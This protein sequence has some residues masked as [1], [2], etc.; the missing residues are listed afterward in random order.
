MKNIFIYS[1][2]ISTI[3]AYNAGYSGLYFSEGLSVSGN[4]SNQE[5]DG[6]RSNAIS[7]GLSY[8]KIQEPSEERPTLSGIYEIS[9]FYNHIESD[10][11][12]NMEML[13]GGLNYY[14]PN[15]LKFGFHYETL[16]DFSGEELDNFNAMGFDVEMTASSKIISIGYYDDKASPFLVFIELMNLDSNLSMDIT[17]NGQQVLGVED[18]ANTSLLRFGAGHKIDNLAIQAM[19]TMNEDKF[20]EARYTLGVIYGL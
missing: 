5:E 10:D 15:N 9:G 6:E 14:M 18:N 4:Y 13:S 16:Y 20:D 1:I 17:S 12:L 2:L 8:L 3:F 11:G 19:I 7:L